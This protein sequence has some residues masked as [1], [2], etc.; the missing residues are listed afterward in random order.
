[1][2]E[3]LKKYGFSL[4]EE[5]LKDFDFRYSFSV[6]SSVGDILKFN[7]NLLKKDN[8]KIYYY[9]N[10][11]KDLFDDK[12]NKINNK[13]KTI[14]NKFITNKIKD[15]LT[16]LV[17]N[18][19]VLKLNDVNCI[20]NID[21]ENLN[22]KNFLLTN[23]NSLNFEKSSFEKLFN[24]MNDKEK[25]NVIHS[26]YFKSISYKEKQNITNSLGL[27]ENET[28]KLVESSYF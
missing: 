9:E 17:I 12:I 5:K 2:K 10:N 21:M 23:F 26:N 4:E 6:I 18:K 27:N 25:L 13:I 7:K 14:D 20:L 28:N 11:N 15:F 16:Y 8:N 24:L 19:S 22:G 1:M 3:N